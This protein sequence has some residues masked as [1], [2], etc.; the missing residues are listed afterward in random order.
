MVPP[1]EPVEPPTLTKDKNSREARNISEATNQEMQQREKIKLLLGV[2]RRSEPEG[3]EASDVG[4]EQAE[5][6]SGTGESE[7]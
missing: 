4:K 1:V 2:G 7:S 3:G 5:A 6:W